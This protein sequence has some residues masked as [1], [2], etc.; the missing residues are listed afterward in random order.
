M[1]N[2][3][4]SKLMV[5]PSDFLETAGWDVGTDWQQRVA[6]TDDAR[7]D[8]ARTDIP[9]LRG[10]DMA[11][12]VDS[13]GRAYFVKA[14]VRCFGGGFGPPPKLQTPTL[15]TYSIPDR[16]TAAVSRPFCLSPGMESSSMLDPAP[17]PY[18]G[19]RTWLTPTGGILWLHETYHK[20]R[21]VEW[22]ADGTVRY[23]T[24]EE[25]APPDGVD[26]VG[27]NFDTDTIVVHYHY[28]KTHHVAS[29]LSYASGK[30][31]QFLATRLFLDIVKLV[32]PLG[33]ESSALV[34]RA[35]KD[36]HRWSYVQY[37]DATAVAAI[38]QHEFGPEANSTYVRTADDETFV[39]AGDTRRFAVFRPEDGVLQCFTLFTTSLTWHHASFAEAV[40]A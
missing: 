16:I 33:V 1:Q 20:W 29:V 3:H 4:K 5:C 23:V 24:A 31:T 9:D 22:C 13:D 19:I 12:G 37:K 7:T 6:M 38:V 18:F 28:S 36:L 39:F 27:V 26:V 8:D 40:A 17:Y 11:Q 14:Q 15:Y 34:A 21:L 32:A 35:R 25:T 10:A 2:L 30:E